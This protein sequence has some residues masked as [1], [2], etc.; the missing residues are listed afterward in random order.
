VFTVLVVAVIGF[1]VLGGDGDEDN[2]NDALAE[3]GVTEIPAATL[4]S[5]VTI[6]ASP[7]DIPPAEATSYVLMITVNEN[8]SIMV[9]NNITQNASLPLAPLSM[10]NDIETIAGLD[11][12]VDMLGSQDCLIIAK[13]QTRA[14]SLV[15]NCNRVGD[16]IFRDADERF[17][18]SEITVSYDDVSVATCTNG[19]CIVQIAVQP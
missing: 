3:T 7:T 17:W 15:T 8:L 12:G 2:N 5:E 18:L 14:D 4:S 9:I 10:S 13:D 16:P 6:A 1:F 11:F 19:T